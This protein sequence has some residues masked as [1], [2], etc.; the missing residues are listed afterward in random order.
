MY[1]MISIVNNNVLSNGNLL[2]QWIS[3]TLMTDTQKN[4]Y[5]RRMYVN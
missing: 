1:N 3:G 4:N 5:V 2:R